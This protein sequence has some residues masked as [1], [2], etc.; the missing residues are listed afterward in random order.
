MPVHATAAMCAP[1]RSSRMTCVVKYSEPGRV[2]GPWLSTPAG[3]QWHADR[4]DRIDHVP[5]ELGKSCGR[6]EA[7]QPRPSPLP[8]RLLRSA[9][10]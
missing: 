4:V 3:E 6:L 5:I 1:P 7:I 2:V 10:G 8:R 9:R